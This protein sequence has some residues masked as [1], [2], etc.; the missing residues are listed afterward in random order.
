[1]SIPFLCF[2]LYFY[3]FTTGSTEHVFYEAEI[4]MARMRPSS[5]T[6]THY[7]VLSPAFHF[8][9][10]LTRVGRLWRGG[11]CTPLLRRHL[12]HRALPSALRFDTS[13]DCLLS[14]DNIIITYLC[15]DGKTYLCFSLYLFR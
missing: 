12:C 9:P 8:A 11:W 14:F 10:S 4:K 5:P 15:A 3:P 2:V 13:F 6:L 7:R 1:M